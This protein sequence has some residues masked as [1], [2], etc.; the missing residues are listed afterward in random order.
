MPGAG[1]RSR[2]KTIFAPKTP[3]KLTM[4][5]NEIWWHKQ[6]NEG[7]FMNDDPEYQEGTIAKGK[8]INLVLGLV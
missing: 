8:V 1:D 2:S 5:I 3:I 7:L 4:S 6:L